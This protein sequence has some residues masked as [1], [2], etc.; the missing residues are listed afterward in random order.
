MTYAGLVA[1]FLAASAVPF[2]AAVLLRRPGRRW[3][4]AQGLT[5][6]A[7]GVLT[8]VFDSL[9]IAADLFRYEESHLSGLHVW[10]APVE[11]FAW[12]LAAVMVVPSLTLLLDRTA[13]DLPARSQ[14]DA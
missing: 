3:W 8:A 14:E 2:V 1:L 11:D 9:M 13:G 6:L 7:L 4:A 5:L 10:L 12:P